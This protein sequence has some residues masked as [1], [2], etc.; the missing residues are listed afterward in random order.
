MLTVDEIKSIVTPVADVYPIRRV[1]LFGSYARGDATENS[2]VD[3]VIDSDGKLNG[4]NF[5]IY[6]DKLAKALPVKSDIFESIEIKK[7]SSLYTR[8][9]TEG[10][11]LYERA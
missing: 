6:A 9:L 3:I 5:F 11:V 4:I 2:D 1:T 7:P 8:I 10:V